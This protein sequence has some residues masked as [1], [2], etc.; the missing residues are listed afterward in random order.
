MPKMFQY[1]GLIYII[2]ENSGILITGVLN[3]NHFQQIVGHRA[4]NKALPRMKEMGE[5]LKEAIR[6][7]SHK[8]KAM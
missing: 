1:V 2:A 4:Q 3:Q 8:Y 7:L 6:H 5:I